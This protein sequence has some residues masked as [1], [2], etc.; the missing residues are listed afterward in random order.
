MRAKTLLCSLALVL[1]AATAA[2]AEPVNFKEFIPLVS[3]S[4]PGFT[5][6]TPSGTTVKAPVEASEAN[7]EFTKDDVRLEITIFDGGPAMGAAMA[8]TQQID[9]E[10]SEE[11]IKSVTVKGFKGTL[12]LRAKDKDG[13]LVLMVPPRFAVTLHLN[14]AA[15]GE[16]LKS[17]AEK[18]DMAKLSTMAK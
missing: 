2:L 8:A 13:D 17:V 5:A 1:L 6:G 15:D 11:S 10:T 18:I 14:G 16:L 7:I 12:Y 9:M 3:V 4:V